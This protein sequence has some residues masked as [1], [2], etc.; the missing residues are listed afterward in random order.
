MSTETLIEII[1][2]VKTTKVP[3]PVNGG[4]DRAA[5]ITISYQLFVA[6]LLDRY[7]EVYDPGRQ[8]LYQDMTLPLS[9][10]YISSSHNTY[11]EGDQITSNSS[12]NR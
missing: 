3:L 6:I 10:Y 5:G 9:H 2:T 8:E 12:V 11:L 7:N 4:N 1:N